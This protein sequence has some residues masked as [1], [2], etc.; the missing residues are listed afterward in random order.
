MPD[1]TPYPE[2]LPELL[3][4]VGYGRLPQDQQRFVADRALAMRFTQQELRQLV[5]IALD[6]NMWGE[7][8]LPAIWP[9]TL[10]DQTPAKQQRQRILSEL[11]GH[12]QRLREAPNHYPD[13]V[14][15]SVCASERI[16]RIK[17]EK[18]DLGLGACP[19]AS[20][21]TRCCNLLTLD[22]V[23]NCGFDCSY[24]SI[25]SFY[26]GDEV[27]FD[28]GFADKL[29]GLKLDPQQTY[30]IGTGQ[31]SDSLMWGNQAG[32]LD[33]LV[34]FAEANPNVILELKT[35]SKNISYLLKHPIPPNILCTWS[36]NT[37]TLIDHEE[38]LT[39]SLEE[40][41][42][43]ARRLADQGILVG[44]HF[45]PMIHY[46]RWRE[47]YTALFQRL[48]RMFRPEEVV[49]VSLGTLTYIKPVIRQLRSRQGFR[50]KILQMPL[51]ESDG[52]LSY[53]EAIKLEMFS[54]AHESLS[55][56]HGEVFFYLCMENQRLWR[57]V[58]GFDYASNDEFEQAMKRSY[59]AKIEQRRR[60]K[61]GIS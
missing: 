40:R 1:K 52:K 31:S 9:T 47:D 41:L 45:H 42:Q 56:W 8:P 32:I 27:R 54:L 10:Q 21:R 29:Q 51:V 48:V 44:F 2:K 18:D 50:S 55:L 14:A 33:A 26:H 5:D 22:A 24:C 13:R 19:V 20:L 7:A 11:K 23:E 59:L 6:L 57:P 4:Q 3:R 34:S 12:W 36:L 38:H 16:K 43:S 39:A 17:V 46:D 37:Q 28:Q 53:P 25:Q 35:K 58:F 61:L 30:H 49:L 15:G 60:V